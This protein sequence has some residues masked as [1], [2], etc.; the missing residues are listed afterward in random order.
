MI[1]SANLPEHYRKVESLITG[2]E[3][4]LERIVSIASMNTMA[5]LQSR[6]TTNADGTIRQTAPNVRTVN[7][8][9]RI[10]QQAM[11]EAGYGNLIDAF[12]QDFDG[13]ITIFEEV[14]KDISRSFKVRPQF[15]DR[16]FN[17][18]E[19]VKVAVGDSLEAVTDVVARAAVFQ[20]VFSIGGTSFPDLTKVLSER[21]R[22]TVGEARNLAATGISTFYRTVANTG[23]KAIEDDLD[24]FEIRYTYMGPPAGDKL[25]RPFCA[26]LMKQAYGGR[27]W[28][29]AQIEA[30]NNGQLPDVF[31][32]GGGY[33]CRHQWVISVE[34]ES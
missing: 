23:Y 27:T 28:T 7:A 4:Q 20:G 14:L 22:M 25:I 17:F 1:F 15:S 32:T 16:D 12:I 8:L 10:F 6:L 26:K 31:N 33:N 29:R 3:T 9:P 18:F 13:Q 19:Q 5:Q 30:M 21:L 24:T 11:A 2:F 34:D